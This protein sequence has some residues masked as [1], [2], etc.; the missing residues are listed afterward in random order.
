[1]DMKLVYLAPASRVVTFNLEANFCESY[2]SG[3]VSF[4]DVGGS[5]GGSV[6]DFFDDEI[7]WEP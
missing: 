5:G 2:P 4:G 7:L 1:M 6:D 3:S